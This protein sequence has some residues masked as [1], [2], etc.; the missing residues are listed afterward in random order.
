MT[1]L[2]FG[3]SDSE[4]RI[5]LLFSDNGTQLW[6]TRRLT[7]M[8]LVHLADR[9]EKTC[10]GGE[11]QGSLRASTRVALE[12]EAAHEPPP[13]APEEGDGVAATGQQ[14]GPKEPHAP[15]VPGNIHRLSSISMSLRGN[16]VRFDFIA[17]GFSRAMDLTRGETHKLLGALTRRA[18]ASEWNLLNL[19][20][21]LVEAA[22]AEAH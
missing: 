7:N 9:M 13:D 20:L 18:A 19:P 5:W 21:W 22:K 15:P 17:P 10:P 11:M 4:D 6:L 16:L 8:L 12:H 14:Q 3:Y 1:Q 2:T